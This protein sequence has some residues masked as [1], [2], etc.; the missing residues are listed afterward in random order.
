MTL[1]LH[2]F[3]QRSGILSETYPT[4]QD[5]S[6]HLKNPFQIF[7][8]PSPWRDLFSQE[9]TKITFPTSGGRNR[10][11]SCNA[12][13]K[14][15]DNEENLPPLVYRPISIGWLSPGQGT[16]L[17][18]KTALGAYGGQGESGLGREHREKTAC[19]ARSSAGCAVQ[20]GM[21][22]RRK[23]GD[24]ATGG[25]LGGTHSVR[26][27]GKARRKPGHFMITDGRAKGSWPKRDNI[28]VGVMST[29]R[30]CGARP[31]AGGEP[32]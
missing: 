11:P 9:T 14:E 17:L 7:L 21:A 24:E 31:S 23:P 20:G 25:F 13:K 27:C 8:G 30:A 3:V 2:V 28:W 6:P 12:P 26:P 16:L 32:S 29:L 10:N 1:V 19:G 15:P 5:N 4:C 22:S 18:C